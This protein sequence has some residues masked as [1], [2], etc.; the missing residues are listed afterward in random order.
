[1]PI[2]M[3]RSAPGGWCWRETQLGHSKGAESS[4]CGRILQANKCKSQIHNNS[5]L[6][7]AFRN[8]YVEVPLWMHV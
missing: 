5:I 4:T 7:I 3:I 1:M 8:I 6:P 2:G